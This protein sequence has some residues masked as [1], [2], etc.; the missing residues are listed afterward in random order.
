MIKILSSPSP[1]F[2]SLRNSRNVAFLER[3]RNLRDLRTLRD[4]IVLRKRG[5]TCKLINASFI[6]TP[7][8]TFCFVKCKTATSACILKEAGGL[9]CMGGFFD[10]N[11]LIY[12]LYSPNTLFD[13]LIGGFLSLQVIYGFFF[14]I[15]QEADF[16]FKLFYWFHLFLFAYLSK[17]KFLL[18][19]ALANF[20]Y[21]FAVG[22]PLN[23][24]G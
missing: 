23:K 13:Y 19:L 5:D 11:N 17:F 15:D 8:S 14:V 4:H 22:A 20:L 6:S 18:G 1:C 10:K 16:F 21:N 7:A 12:L 9:F 2:F 3:K 24:N